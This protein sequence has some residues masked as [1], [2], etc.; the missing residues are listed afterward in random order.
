MEELW[1][2]ADTVLALSKGE[3]W[4]QVPRQALAMGIPAIVTD[5]PCWMDLS[6]SEEGALYRVRLSGTLQDPKFRN[7]RHRCFQVLKQTNPKPLN[8]EF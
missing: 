5:L 1:G 2:R 4:G 6:S 7:P 3:G 8:P